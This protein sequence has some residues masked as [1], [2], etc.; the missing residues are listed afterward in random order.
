MILANI[1]HGVVDLGLLE[2]LKNLCKYKI[3]N[4]D[5]LHKDL[6]RE[7]ALY[8][9]DVSFL[10][11]TEDSPVE[12]KE[13]ENEEELLRFIDKDFKN[14]FKACIPEKYADG[15]YLSPRLADFIEKNNGRFPDENELENLEQEAEDERKHV[16]WKEYGN[17]LDMLSEILGALKDIFQSR[18]K[19]DTREIVF[20]D[21]GDSSLSL[22]VEEFDEFVIC[23]ESF[24]DGKLEYN[25][26][27]RKDGFH[28][29][30]LISYDHFDRAKCVYMGTL[31]EVDDMEQIVEIHKCI[32]NLL[33]Q[34]GIEFVSK[35]I[36]S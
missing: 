6:L 26:N 36:Y 31:K 14:K 32:I 17:R 15:D 1:Y 25:L 5:R 12:N 13:I 10:S 27:V 22:E 8:I 21:D 34:E 28:D 9:V 18:Q 4:Y 3:A 20:D 11:G 33:K 16:I 24:L 29:K 2:K 30:L 23:H 7:G 35:F 19:K